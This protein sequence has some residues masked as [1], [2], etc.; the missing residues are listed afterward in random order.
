MLDIKTRPAGT[1][2]P[3]SRDSRR[4]LRYGI[5]AAAAAVLVA[6][7]VALFDGTEESSP[8]DVVDSPTDPEPLVDV[9][10]PQS[11]DFTFTRA[12]AGFEVCRGTEEMAREAAAEA[13]R[14]LDAPSVKGGVY[15][16]ILDPTLAGVFVHEAFGHLSESDFVSAI[17]F[18]RTKHRAK[19]LARQLSAS[20]FRAVALQGN[21]SQNQR[22]RAMT[23]FRGD[24]YDVLVATDIAARGLDVDHV[25][26]VVNFDVPTTTDAYTHRI[27]R[28]GR[29]ERKGR[30]YT[31]VT[32]DDHAFV[33]AVE[34]KIGASL[35]RRLPGGDTASGRARR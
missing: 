20:G 14:Q 23:G 26:H 5:L 28:T 27:G 19:R 16:V 4:W 12:N 33:R 31:F 17:V 2:D 34:R 1:D 3:E 24:R 11:T 25:T 6:I 8:V 10:A 32:Q 29:A 9:E 22:E 21:M 15:P 7:A 30:A 13:R 18:T 35:P